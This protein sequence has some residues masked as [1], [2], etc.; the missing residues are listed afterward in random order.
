M[1]Q[2]HVGVIGD[3]QQRS[4]VVHPTGHLGAGVVEAARDATAG[5]DEG[6]GQRRSEQ[7]HLLRRR[8][9]TEHGAVGAH[10]ALQTAHAQ[11]E[12]EDHHVG[13]LVGRHAAD[14]RQP[15]AGVDQHVFG[16]EV[17]RHGVSKRLGEATLAKPGPI[18]PVGFGQV[19][20]HRPTSCGHDVEAAEPVKGRRFVDVGFEGRH[21]ASRAPRGDTLDGA[22]RD[23]F[24]VGQPDPRQRV[25]VGSFE[26]EVHD[27]HAPVLAGERPRHI[28]QRQRTPDAAFVGVERDEERHRHVLGTGSSLRAR[29]SLCQKLK[30]ERLG[31]GGCSS[32]AAHVLATRRPRAVSKTARLRPSVSSLR[33]LMR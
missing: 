13:H 10:R 21:G 7:R 24:V 3:P 8:A 15:G 22:G 23:R 9:F 31:A 30:F 14:L 32:G 29:A 2:R 19:T 27:E 5:L 11:V 1:V 28:G 12:E 6:V 17:A 26:I 33:R 16:V 18:Q 25:E 20:S 4:P